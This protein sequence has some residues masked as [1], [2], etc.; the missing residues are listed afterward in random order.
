[1]KKPG[2]TPSATLNVTI[3]AQASEPPSLIC[4]Q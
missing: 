4:F 3:Y 1:M 2:D